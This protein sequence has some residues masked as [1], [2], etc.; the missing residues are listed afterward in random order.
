MYGDF[1]SVY[2]ELMEDVD[3]KAWAAYYNAVLTEAGIDKGARVTECACGTGSLTV[4]LSLQYEM[5]GV[6]ISQEMLSQ[7]AQ[8][9][10]AAG[11]TVP[12]IRQDMRKLTLH[13]AQDAILCTCD[14][15]NYLPDEKSL[16]GF[17]DAACRSL[18]PGG[19]LCFDVSSFYKLSTVLG[20]KILTNTQGRVHYIWE[21]VWQADERLLDMRLQ[22]YAREQGNI[23]RHMEETQRQ[24]AW[25]A[26]ELVR[27]LEESGFERPAVCGDR[28]FEPPRDR[29]MRLHLSA[30]K[31]LH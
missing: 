15:V 11:R 12:L 10:R 6:D 25:T 9:L 18:R 19:V 24:R 21:N 17:F 29:E 5:T 2:D 31:P 4:Y 14:G 13:K 23:F 30:R 22:L 3:Y 8:K 27:A 20:N 1:A 26:D 28:T 7:A 16:R